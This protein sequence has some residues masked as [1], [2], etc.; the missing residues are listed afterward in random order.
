MGFPTVKSDPWKK[1]IRPRPNRSLWPESFWKK[2]MDVAWGKVEG[3]WIEMI[4]DINETMYGK[5]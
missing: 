3:N 1:G 5:R 2:L 4:G